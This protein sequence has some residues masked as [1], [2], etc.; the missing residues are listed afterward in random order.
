[1]FSWLS[2]LYINKNNRHEREINQEGES[3]KREEEQHETKQEQQ[4]DRHTL[5]SSYVC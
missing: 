4:V 2:F 5:R 3:K 1:M